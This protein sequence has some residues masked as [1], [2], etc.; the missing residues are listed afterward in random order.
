MAAC[1]ATKAAF[2]IP[3][4]GSLFLRKTPGAYMELGFQLQVN[5]NVF[6]KSEVLSAVKQPSGKPENHS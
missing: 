3:Q 2:F 6:H 1:C 4:E 5:S